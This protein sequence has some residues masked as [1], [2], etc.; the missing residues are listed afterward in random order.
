MSLGA[1][2]GHWFYFNATA[3]KVDANETHLFEVA[4]VD[5]TGNTSYHNLTITVLN[6]SI[7]P[8]YT[9]D[10]HANRDFVQDGLLEE[11]QI[12]YWDNESGIYNSDVKKKCFGIFLML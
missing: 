1:S 8:S 7:A 10:S 12:T 4:V 2:S 5:S 3:P 11:F 6:D 9:L